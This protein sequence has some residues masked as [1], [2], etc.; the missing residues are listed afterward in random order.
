MLS[1]IYV[2]SINVGCLLYILYCLLRDIAEQIFKISVPLSKNVYVLSK[3]II[4]LRLR[5][6]HYTTVCLKIFLI[7]SKPIN[8]FLVDSFL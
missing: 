6:L 4:E 5:Q 1:K 8:F 2:L 3:N 7:T